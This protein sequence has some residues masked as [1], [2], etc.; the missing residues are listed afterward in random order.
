MPAS[1]SST[2]LLN[3]FS[4]AL[5]YFL[6]MLVPFFI[7][8]LIG[9]F[10][11]PQ[12]FGR[13]AV[14][15]SFMSVLGLFLTFGVANV[16]SFEIALWKKDDRQEIAEILRT[17][18]VVLLLFTAAGFA[19][20]GA[21]LLVLPYS[22]EIKTIILALALGYFLMAGHSVLTSV[23]IG[24][25]E[26][27]WI[28]PSSLAN[29]FAVLIFVVPMIFRRHPLPQVAVS[30]SLTQLAGVLVT[31]YYLNKN[32][33]LIPAKS[34][35]TQILYTMKRSFGVGLDNVIYKVGSDLTNII[36]PF[37]LLESQIGIFNGAFK[38]YVLL[39]AGNQITIQFFLPYLAAALHE[40]KQKKESLLNIFHKVNVLFTFTLIILPLFFARFLNRF[41][42]GSQLQDSVPFMTFLA[43]GYLVYYLPPYAAPLKAFKKEWRVL[44]S[45]S[46]QVLVN[47]LAILVLVPRFGIRGAVL[48]VIL[49]FFSYWLANI[50]LYLRE[51]LKPV[52]HPIHY[53]AYMGVSLG[54]GFAI[55][56]LFSPNL[57]SLLLFE[58]VN[59]FL[60]YWVLLTKKERAGLDSFLK[61]A[62][63]SLPFELS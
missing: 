44:I 37:F 16:A 30:W 14:A 1:R 45:S 60:A 48:A 20:M 52:S 50:V 9:R 23:F 25:K 19:A 31:I 46:T 62:R 63:T 58:I 32:H 28:I 43:V 36:L 41:L 6:R 3:Y 27:K 7:I 61:A 56:A 33:Y 53:G 26:M 8:V 55:T 38:P 22:P 29:L 10:Y 49:A 51:K 4:I 15:T 24:I 11:S 5:V 13:Y 47:L 54:L 42:F 21:F 39:I 12:Q 17:S 40:D 34:S 57:V 18:G 2:H 59:L 35:K